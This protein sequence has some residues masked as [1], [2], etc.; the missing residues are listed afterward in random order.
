MSECPFLHIASHLSKAFAG[1]KLKMVQM[2]GFVPVR[3]EKIMGF[4]LV[5]AEKI[6]GFVLV[7]A[8]KI[9][10]FVLGKE[11]K[12][13]GFV[14]VKAEK[15]MGFVLARAEKTMVQKRK[16]WFS[17]FST[18]TTILPCIFS[19]YHKVFKPYFIKACNFLVIEN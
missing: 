15:I 10:G 12:I 6:M 7:K 2:M 17:A 8:E 14:L 1:D 4:V 18:V 11:E 13:M 16:F 5:K 3:V 9:M 19:F